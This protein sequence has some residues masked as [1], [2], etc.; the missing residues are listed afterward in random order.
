MNSLAIEELT[1]GRYKNNILIEGETF[2][3]N[4]FKSFA[5]NPAD[6]VEVRFKNCSFN[7]CSIS[8]GAFQ[9][10]KNVALERV[11]FNNIKMSGD[12]DI[13]SGTKITNSKF[14]SSNKEDMLW[15][16][17]VMG[18][19]ECDSNVIVLDISEFEGQVIITGNDVSRVRINVEKQIFIY[20]ELLNQDYF[21]LNRANFFRSSASK[22]KHNGSRVGVFSVP[23]IKLVSGEFQEQLEY[24]ESRGY[25]ARKYC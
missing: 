21:K 10:G 14:V 11:I 3:G 9:L 18:D 20:A 12:F 2:D 8:R 1:V 4:I 7:N 22:V 16:K 17:N 23:E 13:H 24:F 25:V 5:I 6:G 19:P 15:V